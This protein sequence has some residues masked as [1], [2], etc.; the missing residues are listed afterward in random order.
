MVRMFNS[1]SSV[2][3]QNNPNGIVCRMGNT[4]ISWKQFLSDISSLTAKLKKETGSKKYLLY[5]K[6]S[7]QF[8]V[9][10]FSVW[11]SGSVCVLP[12]NNSKEVLKKFKNYVDAFITDQP[13]EETEF[14][15][16]T[17]LQSAQ[18]RRVDFYSIPEN[19][20]L[21]ELFTSGTTGERKSV[22]KTLANL[23][24][25][26]MKLHEIFGSVLEN[27][28]TF[29]TVS[30]QHIYGLLHKI[31][32][33]ICENRVFVDETYFYPEKLITDMANAEISSVLVS[34]PAHLKLLPELASLDGL[35][36]FCKAVFSSG[37]LL[38][39]ETAYK[40][41]F[42]SGVS[43]IEVLGSTETG[44]VAWRSQNE[45]S[46]SK[47]WT[48][49]ESVEICKTENGFLQVKSPFIFLEDTHDKWFT[50]GD[51]VEIFDNNRFNLYGRGDRIVKIGEKR[52]SLEEMEAVL[53]TFRIVKACF[54]FPI[55]RNHLGF[56]R[57]VLACVIEV[58]ESLC[59]SD[60]K[61]IVRDFK[62][63]LLQHFAQILV[64]KY[65]RFVKEIPRDAQGKTSIGELENLFRK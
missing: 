15:I 11:Q 61:K 21:L 18:Y 3:I 50:M 23:N 27:T 59:S 40:L 34:G 35:S 4:D 29:S 38:D 58:S 51:I 25:E 14:E 28:T 60:E 41:R 7:Y 2:I 44:G 17:P 55:I 20:V 42:Q 6:S 62:N 26:L 24:M 47:K 16:I 43:P 54:V 37:S 53:K 19:V 52:L 9:A 13:S 1:L 32:L 45:T 30:H 49:F 33:P 22:K 57:T 56:D 46:E 31:L 64:P 36:K 5:C 12:P 63:R 65:W 48:P 39:E 10:L 8:T